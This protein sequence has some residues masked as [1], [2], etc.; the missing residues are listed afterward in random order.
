MH[1]TDLTP[2]RVAHWVR[3]DW[4]RKRNAEPG[5]E[6][7]FGPFGEDAVCLECQAAYWRDRI[8]MDRACA[9]G[10]AMWEGAQRP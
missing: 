10:R 2:E 8:D 1:P 7:S 6:G 9:A 5:R 3:C 4:C